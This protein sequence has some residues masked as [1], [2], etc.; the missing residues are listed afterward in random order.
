MLI[1]SRLNTDW[2]GKLHS[3]VSSNKLKIF[4]FVDCSSLNLPAVPQLPVLCF[5]EVFEETP[6]A[7]ALRG[8]GAAH[9]LL[10]IGIITINYTLRT[11]NILF[12]KPFRDESNGTKQHL[13]KTVRGRADVSRKSLRAPSHAPRPRC[14]THTF[15]EQNA[16]DSHSD[17]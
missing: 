7:V 11:E 6:P 2:F 13:I 17:P 8:I 14:I 9:P 1:N 15:Y 10:G 3:L 12:S 5:W 16:N 4:G